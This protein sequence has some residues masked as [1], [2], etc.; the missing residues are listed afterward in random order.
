MIVKFF[1]EKIKAKKI[2]KEIQNKVKKILQ[3]GQYTNSK[4]VGEFEKIFRKNFKTKYCVAVNNGTSALHLSLL[5]LGI[6]KNDEILVPSMTFIASAAAINYVGAKPIFVDVNEKDW[7]INPN[8]I[9]KFINKKTKAI[10]VVH[11]HGLMCDMDKI[12]K[13]ANK[14]KLKII[15]DAAQAHGSSFKNKLPGHYSDVATFSFYPTK[16]LG[17]VG[18]GGAII[19]NDKNIFEKTKR[20]RTWSH[21]KHSFYELSFNYRMA[22]FSA[23]SLI[24]KIRFLSSDIKKRISIAKRYKKYLITK[25]YSEYNEKLKQHSYH[26]FAIKVDSS[27]RS[28]IIHELKLKGIDTN[29]HYPYSLSEL[30]VFNIRKIKNKSYIANKISKELLSLPIYP[31]LEDKKIR[32][33][34]KIINQI[35]EN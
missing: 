1:S 3:T 31:E 14:Y 30:K 34:A 28:K 21:N 33:T 32:Y 11:L 9:E 13:I 17:A 20:M 24:S 18:E 29:I 19:T 15:E 25:K 27:K 4:Y 2:T 12:K 16:N 23:I 5:A 7:L 10:M 8:I 26:I 22:E 6:K 35:L